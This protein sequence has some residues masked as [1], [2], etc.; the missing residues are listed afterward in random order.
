M[1]A[2]EMKIGQNPSTILLTILF[3]LAWFAF[4]PAARAQCRDGC[5]VNGNTFLG[6]VSLGLDT[7]GE[8]ITAIAV[9]ALVYNTT[10]SYNVAVGND[11][12]LFNTTASYNPAVGVSTLYSNATSDFNKR[13]HAVEGEPI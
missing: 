1:E 9:L 3:A 10:G 12:F 4:S 2:I 7:S 5:G 8:R 13:N 11:A 6:D